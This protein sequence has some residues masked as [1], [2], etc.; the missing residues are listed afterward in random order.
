MAASDETRTV[1]GWRKAS[2]LYRRPPGL[3]WL[4]ALLAIPLLLG[5]LG[6]AML[7]KSTKNV[8]VT[9]STVS[10]SPTLSMP[11]VTPPNVNMPGLGFAP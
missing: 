3:G 7:D 11:S 9:M 6:W 10:P 8:D 5:W 4:L 2:R 1:T